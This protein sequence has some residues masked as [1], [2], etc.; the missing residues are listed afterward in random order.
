MNKLFQNHEPL[1]P[2]HTHSPLPETQLTCGC[3]HRPITRFA[4]TRSRLGMVF[5]DSPGVVTTPRLLTIYTKWN[6]S[7]V[8]LRQDALLQPRSSCCSSFTFCPQLTGLPAAGWP[9]VWGKPVEPPLYTFCC[10]QSLWWFRG[11][12]SVRPVLSPEFLSGS[13]CKISSP[14][15]GLL[16]ITFLAG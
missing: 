8:L 12:R 1:F 6:R 16:F 4:S 9:A 2:L 3:Y 11:D 7:L 14:R 13:S 10:D 15:S 5:L